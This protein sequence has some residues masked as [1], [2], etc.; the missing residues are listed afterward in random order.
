MRRSLFARENE[1]QRISKLDAF[2]RRTVNGGL[3]GDAKQFHNFCSSFALSAS[4]TRR[5][6]AASPLTTEDDAIIAAFLRVLGHDREET[7]LGPFGG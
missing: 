3:Q 2:V 1:T 5:N 4:W 6:G 7:P